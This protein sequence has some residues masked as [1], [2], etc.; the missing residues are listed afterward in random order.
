MA[1]NNKRSHEVKPFQF[2]SFTTVANPNGNSSVSNYE[3]KKLE[4]KS[5]KERVSQDV[6]RIERKLEKKNDFSVLSMIRES[7]GMKEQEERDYHEAIEA[8]V[9]Q[10]LN[11]IKEQA[12]NQGFEEGLKQG[13]DK[14][15]AETMMKLDERVE[16][17]VD[18]LNDLKEKCHSV[19]KD[20]KNQTLEL[21][22]SLTQWIVL[23]EVK[24]VGYLERLLEKLIHELNTR[25]NLLVRVGKDF[26]EDMPEI[27]GKVEAKLGE[28]PNI[29]IEVDHDL[30]STGII[31]ESENGIID[32]SMKA[33]ME[34]LE[35]IFEKVR[36]DE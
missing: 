24:D 4:A 2:Q 34:S 13:H 8:Q 1:V 10:R 25:S 5:F 35:K 29:R 3:L 15:Y 32:A 12:K 36:I 7:R 17:F 27:V 21:V 28:L 6:I 11:Q 26:F 31:L 19:L 23:K 20:N 30:D 18:I 16:D 33:Q 14:A 22:K 9:Q